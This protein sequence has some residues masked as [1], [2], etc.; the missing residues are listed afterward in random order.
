L[1][2]LA[3]N[4][5]EQAKKVKNN[6]ELISQLDFV[7]SVYRTVGLL[8]WA[9]K[10]MEGLKGSDNSAKLQFLWQLLGKCLLIV[11]ML[12]TRGYAIAFA[13]GLLL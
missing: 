10:Q 1:T 4:L 3:L 8:H 5:Y 11:K 6:E 13:Q 2:Q 9:I 12:T 7:L